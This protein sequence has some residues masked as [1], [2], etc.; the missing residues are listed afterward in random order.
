MTAGRPTRR[1]GPLA[2]DR[3]SVETTPVASLP[4]SA[5]RSPL[6]QA[7]DLTAE[8]EGCGLKHLTVLAPQNDPFRIDTRANHRDGEWLAIYAESLIGQRPIHLRG[9]HYAL[10][11]AAPTKPNGDTYRNTDNDWKWMQD[12]A[13]DAARWLGYIPFDRIIDQR[14]AA[15]EV[16]VFTAPQT[17]PY[18]SIGVDVDI[19]A[20]DDIEPSVGAYHLS[21][22]G[23]GS[24]GGFGTAQPYMGP[25]DLPRGPIVH[26]SGRSSGFP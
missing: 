15:P 12:N 11:T 25:S 19:P 9:L 16:R 7:L 22:E 13:S 20:A 24:S 6:R 10:V 2:T 8:Q 17:T 5:S 21:D 1:S 23:T 4:Q 14:S 26:V 18:V 3:P